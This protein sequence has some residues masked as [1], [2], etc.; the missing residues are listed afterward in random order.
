MGSVTV[1]GKIKTEKPKLISPME[2][3]HFSEP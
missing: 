2:Y 3:I 1:G